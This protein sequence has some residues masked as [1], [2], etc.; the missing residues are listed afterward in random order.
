MCESLCWLAALEAMSHLC[1]RESMH[2]LYSA[3]FVAECGPY[4]SLCSVLSPLEPSRGS[5]LQEFCF[6]VI[7]FIGSFE[8]KTISLVTV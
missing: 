5:V 8:A 6:P 1:Y 4:S 7:T 2:D 3:S